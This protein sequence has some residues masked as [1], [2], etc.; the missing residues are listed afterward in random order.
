MPYRLVYTNLVIFTQ[1][2]YSPCFQEGNSLKL[3][4]LVWKCR[5]NTARS[6]CRKWNFCWFSMAA[7]LLN[8]KAVCPRSVPGP[9]SSLQIKQDKLDQCKYGGDGLG[10]PFPFPFPFPS[11]H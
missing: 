2:S 4:A 11:A 5:F 1:Y 6:F 10:C 7:E 8:F 3:H 9:L